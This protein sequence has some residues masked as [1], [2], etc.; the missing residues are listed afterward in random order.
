M[1]TMYYI[2]KYIIVRVMIKFCIEQLSFSSLAN[3]AS[4]NL[5]FTSL[6]NALLHK[7]SRRISQLHLDNNLFTDVRADTLLPSGAGIRISFSSDAHSSQ[8][9]YLYS[10]KK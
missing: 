5:V 6:I 8:Y 7:S 10:L 3:D 9:A 1:I 2:C 4:R